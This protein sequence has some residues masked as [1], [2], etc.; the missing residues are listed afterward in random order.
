MQDACPSKLG[1]AVLYLQMGCYGIGVERVICSIIE[2]NNDARG[3]AF[4]E[5]VA[6][7]AVNI[8]TANMKDE[9]QVH[10]SEEIYN[11]LTALGVEVIWDDRADR[12]GSK[13]ADSELI[14]I[15]YNILVGKMAGEGKVEFFKRL[16]EK[17]EISAEEAVNKF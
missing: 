4:P 2:Q 7:F 12:L 6:P 10:L 14:G 11:E 8:I 5:N 16:G 17:I 9:A 13:L 1:E 3:I 15:P